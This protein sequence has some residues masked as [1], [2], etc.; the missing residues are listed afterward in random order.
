MDSCVWNCTLI[1]LIMS[2]RLKQK[3]HLQHYF[4]FSIHVWF[5]LEAS[6]EHLCQPLFSHNTALCALSCPHSTFHYQGFSAAL[7]QRGIL[8]KLFSAP[9]RMMLEIAEV[10]WCGTVAPRGVDKHH[11]LCV[12]SLKSQWRGGRSRAK[13]QAIMLIFVYLSLICL[14]DPFI[15]LSSK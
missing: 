13:D 7:R 11:M 1:T 12:S 9:W 4:P 5:A 8:L 2:N 3:V 14:C 6:W 10:N 15:V